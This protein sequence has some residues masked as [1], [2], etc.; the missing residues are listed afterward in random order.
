MKRLLVSF[1]LFFILAGYNNTCVGRWGLPR[2]KDYFSENEVF[3]GHVTPADGTKKAFLE[4]SKV[5][6]TERAPLWQCTLG[7]E[8]TPEEVFVSNDGNYV[9]TL[10]E[11]S[12]RVP[13]GRGDYVIAF[14]NK[15]RLI[16][17]YSLE[18]I[19]HYPEKIDEK[20]FGRLAPV[21]SVGRLWAFRPVFLDN[22]K[23]KL[24]FC[25]WLTHGCRW[26]GWDVR[27]G[28]E[29]VIDDNSTERWNRK[30][31]AWALKEIEQGKPS[32]YQMA[33][34]KFLGEIRNPKD[35]SLIE[36]LLSDENFTWWG[37]E[38]SSK[39]VEQNRH[40]YHLIQYTQASSERS[41]ADQILAKWN[42]RPVKEKPY[43]D[44]ILYFLGKVKG[45]VRLPKTDIPKEGTLWIYLV[46][47]STPKDQWHKKPP[48]QLLIALFGEYSFK[49]FDLEFTEEFPFAISTVTPGEYWVKAVLDKTKP[50]SR[51]E[52]KFYKPQKGDYE[53]TSSQNIIVKAGQTVENLIV[54]CNEKIE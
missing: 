32:S 11:V 37:R 47:G 38:S 19:L 22:Y 4:V 30:G 31:R 48:V 26:L 45:V 25:V 20:E 6:D 27:T 24:F 7:N 14:Y 41:L 49:D 10:N 28:K 42:G 5:K 40:I 18:Q 13:R 15:D 36:E 46:P 8:G 43:T 23:G 50:Y 54:N 9:A 44:S 51:Q 12:R 52:D 2:E 39:M 33:A 35:R 21:S 17:N 53:N 16:K 34:Y 1:T 3:V 29:I